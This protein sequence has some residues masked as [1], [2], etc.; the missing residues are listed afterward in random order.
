MP[1]YVR[2]LRGIVGGEP[3]LQVPS[4]CIA[5]RDGDGRVLLIRHVEG[6][7]WMLPGGAVEPAEVPADAAW[8][9]EVLEEVFRG[10]RTRGFRPA[11]WRP[12]RHV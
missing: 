6:G 12:T 7:V 1:E 8:V 2:W 4:A 11:T 3:L 9:D 5:L 10:G